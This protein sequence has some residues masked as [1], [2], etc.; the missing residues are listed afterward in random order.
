M[1]GV[2]DHQPALPSRAR[3]RRERRARRR[4]R[5]IGMG[6]M[7]AGLAVAG[8]GTWLYVDDQTTDP[9][10]PSV[11]SQVLER[12]TTTLPPSTTTSTFLVLPTEAGGAP[13]VGELPGGTTA[14]QG[15]TVET[16]VPEPTVP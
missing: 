13:A 10:T 3:V 14:T 6:L 4:R 9:V 1:V 16:T 15:T 7:A 8:V 11:Q 5:R 2:T 12:T